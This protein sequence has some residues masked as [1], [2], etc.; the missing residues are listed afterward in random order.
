MSPSAA[1][2]V[3]VDEP[4]S[5]PAEAREKPLLEVAGGPGGISRESLRELWVF[6][7]VLLAFLVRQVKVKYKQAAVGIGWAV[8]QPVLAAA[9]FALFLGKLSRVGSEGAP[10]LL[11]ALGGM[12]AWTYFSGS[13]GAAMDSLV[14]D[15]ALL[16]KVYFPREVLPLAAVGAGLVDFAPALGTFIIASFLYGIAPSLPWLALVLPVLVLATTSA[17]LGLG[18]SGLNVYYRDVR[19]ALPFVLQLGLFASPVVYPLSA[20]PGTWRTV[21]AILNPVAA[22]IDALRRIVIH[23]SWPDFAVTFAALGWALVLALGGYVLF[24][25]LERGFS[26]RV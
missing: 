6:R 2:S 8:I 11:F 7:E 4:K 19:Y 13:A 21:Y 15:Q 1:T 24:K 26:D 22:A 18:L 20:V 5:P 14:S 3:T 17:A 12:A 23:Q 25:R 10:Y 9:L 16:R